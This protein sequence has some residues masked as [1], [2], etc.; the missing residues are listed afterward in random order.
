MGRAGYRLREPVD[1]QLE[2]PTLLAELVSMHLRDLGYGIDKLSDAL[3]LEKEDFAKMYAINGRH[4]KLALDPAQRQA[5]NRDQ[6]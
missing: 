3:A 6:L 5:T 1:I 2:R 4:L